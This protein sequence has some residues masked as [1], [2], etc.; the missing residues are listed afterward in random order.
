[1]NEK[2]NRKK[3]DNLTAKQKFHEDMVLG[4]KF[5]QDWHLFPMI[6][7]DRIEYAYD[8]FL[9]SFVLFFTE[10]NF[11]FGD[12]GFKNFIIWCIAVSLF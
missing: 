7:V 4:S 3:K 2:N 9:R 1:M 12:S 10:T 8:K 6:P 11:G 5:I